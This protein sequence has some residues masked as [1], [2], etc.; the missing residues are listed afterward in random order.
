[1]RKK[2]YVFISCSVQSKLRRMSPG[3]GDVASIIAIVE[4][5]PKLCKLV[6]NLRKHEKTKAEIRVK[7][8]SLLEKLNRIEIHIREINDM[9]PNPN[10]ILEDVD[11]EIIRSILEKILNLFD[12]ET[13]ASRS[14]YRYVLN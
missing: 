11:L 2:T 6:D 13:P 7:C 10:P 4:F 3:I 1:M 14:L 9:N 5:I 12:E 8:G